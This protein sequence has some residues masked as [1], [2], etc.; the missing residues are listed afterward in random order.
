MIWTMTLTTALGS[1]VFTSEGV[2]FLVIIL[3]FWAIRLARVLIP[4]LRGRPAARRERPKLTE[5]NLARAAPP[6]PKVKEAEEAAAESLCAT[7]VFAHVVR[8]YERGEEIITCGYACPPRDMLFAVRE[9]TDHKPKRESSGAK[10][11]DEGTVSLPP[12]EVTATHFRAA[13]AARRAG[14]T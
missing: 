12:L 7:C 11:A 14:G 4:I 3:T 5:M 6:A 1:A 8:G 10:F 13:V 2:V 9:C